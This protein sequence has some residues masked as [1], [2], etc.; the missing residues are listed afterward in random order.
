MIN[1]L[2]LLFSLLI[3]SCDLG[4]GESSDW[5]LVWSDEFNGTSLD[6]GNWN[7]DEGTGAAQGLTGWGNNELEY[8]TDR[9]Q[10]IRIE[11]LAGHGSSGRGLVIEAREES[12]GGKSYTSAR[13]NSKGKREFTYGKIE[14][15]IKLPVEQGN[16]RGIWPAFWMLGANIDTN[17]WPE[18][19]E[20]DIMEVIG[21]DA[22]TVHGN[23][24]YGN[25]WA[26]TGSLTSR[27]HYDLPSGDFGEDFHVFAIEWLPG[28]VRWL[29]DN[30]VYFT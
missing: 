5:Q 24:H 26:Y 21:S 27:N 14:A 13:I 1:L 4:G 25:P 30:E 18:C 19:G 11:D 16:S 3:I 9:S 6:S 20:I 17:P 10:N 23:L 8:Y 12:Y 28:E 22:D 7:Y 15:R 2:L 29:V